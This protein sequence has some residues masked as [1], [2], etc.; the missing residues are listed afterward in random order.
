MG[1][2]DSEK[3]VPERTVRASNAPEYLSWASF[4]IG[5]G[6]AAVVFLVGRWAR[7]TAIWAI[8]C[9]MLA[10]SL[11]W[12][13]LAL[14]FRLR[15]LALQEKLDM[16]QWTQAQ[17]GTSIFQQEAEQMLVTDVARRRLEV[18][19]RWFI[20][21]FAVLF[22][23]L[24]FLLASAIWRYGIKNIDA[25]TRSPLVGGIVM[26][27]VAFVTFLISRYATGMSGQIEWRPL[28]AG[29]SI[30][31]AVAMLSFALAI[32]LAFA[33]FQVLWIERGVAYAVGVL[34]IVLG[35]ET[36]LNVILDIYRP[37]VPGQYDRAPF[38]SR[39]LGLINEPGGILQSL[40]GALD[41]QFGFK[42]SQTWFYK[43][44]EQA[45]VP[46][47]LF[48]VATLYLVSCIVVVQPDQLAMVERLGRPIRQL[49][50]GL[51]IKWPWPFEVVRPY[52]VG[53]VMELPIGY[54]PKLDA[55]GLEE[56]SPLLWNKPHYQ[57]EYSL[58]VASDTGQAVQTPLRG[59]LPVSL[60]KANVP[61]HYRVKDL[62]AFL[63]NHTDPQRT[64]EA[65]CYQQL[66]AFGA[67]ATIET[68]SIGQGRLAESLL[69]TGRDRARRVL[70]DMIQDAAD[71]AGL[72]VQIVFLGVQ[73]IHP[74]VEVVPQYQEVVGAV[75]QKQALIFNALGQQNEQLCS[76]VGSVQDAY[77]LYELAES[78]Q[79]ASQGKGDLQ[80]VAAALD[81]A[82]GAAVG[83]VY[84]IL[85]KAKAYA[86]RRAKESYGAGIRFQ[87]QLEAF[88]AAPR[89]F[90]RQQRLEA[91]AEAIGPIRKYATLA[92]PNDSQVV[93]VDLQDKLMPNLA[94]I[95]PLQ[96]QTK[97]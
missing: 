12:F 75:Q 56:R 28:R 74:P 31:L 96:E 44:L 86:Y 39:L 70:M 84:Q 29:G 30:F 24:E 41:Y 15:R 66:T 50:P 37:R 46:L 18:F 82:F 57:E 20:P 49:E 9:L 88:R 21:I 14:Q 65:I 67:S 43:L 4:V 11:I 36:I 68:D 83:E 27:A 94:D 47:L 6:L 58:L 79:K 93:I 2:V 61:V 62:H 51:H 91:I 63:Y 80:Q 89:V 8:S 55:S 78:Y 22:S 48:G 52:S 19:E 1:V 92:E 85:R 77:S 97:P 76:L 45:I 7:Y 3:A 10:G 81:R 71:R 87:G 73:G 26:S 5:L 25:G 59:A 60:V 33:Q 53:R 40:A 13:V 69:G 34:L 95:G 42:V 32:G 35:A 72:G 17:R 38:D 90:S 16:A 54:R 64:L 23:I